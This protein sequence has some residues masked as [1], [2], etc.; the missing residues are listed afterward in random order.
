M[1]DGTDLRRHGLPP[2]AQP[3]PAAEPADSKVRRAR[4]ALA[5]GWLPDYRYLTPRNTWGH[6]QP[7][8]ERMLA[9]CEH[10][11]TGTITTWTWYHRTITI[12]C[13][14]LRR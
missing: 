6:W 13:S 14:H 9:A 11:T 12:P 7:T 5:L 3:D 10:S 1:S 2:S 4:A 8:A